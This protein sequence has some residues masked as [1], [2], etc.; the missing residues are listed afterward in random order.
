MLK[1]IYLSLAWMMVLFSCNPG[2]KEPA[3]DPSVNTIRLTGTVKYPQSQGLVILQLLNGV[4]LENI[5]TLTLDQ[6]GK[7]ATKLS[8]P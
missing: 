1:Y 8:V 5:D 6:N 4:I 2:S 7:F 3:N